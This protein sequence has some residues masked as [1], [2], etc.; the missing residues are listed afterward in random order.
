[1]GIISLI[2]LIAVIIGLWKMF[3]KAGEPGWASLIPFYNLW[4]LVRISGFEWYWFVGCFIPLVNVIVFIVISIGI[5]KKFGMPV[6]YAAGLFLLPCV[7]YPILGF[8]S[9]QYQR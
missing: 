5:A 2:L 3:E 1:M 7:F 6:I 8:G 4:V 9:A